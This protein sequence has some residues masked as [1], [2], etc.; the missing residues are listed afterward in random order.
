MM[1]PYRARRI[2]VT[3]LSFSFSAAT[4]VSG[5]PAA[6][7]SS[8]RPV[9]GVYF[10]E[11]FKLVEPF[12]RDFRRSCSCVENAFALIPRIVDP[13]FDT[14]KTDSLR[15][16]GEVLRALRETILVGLREDWVFS[17][18][19][20]PR[21][22]ITVSGI[23]ELE[24]QTAVA[25]AARGYLE[26]AEQGDSSAQAELG[27]LFAV[28]LGVAQDDR[29]AAYWYQQAAL[30]NIPD[31]SK[32]MAAMYALGRGV[33]R[34]DQAAFYWLL[35]ARNLQ[36]LAD[37]YACGLGVEQD[38]EHAR[39]LYE[40]EADRG[41]RDTQYQL[42]TMYL[43]GC[44]V[45]LNDELAHKWF[46]KSANNGHPEAQIA[47]SEMNN[48]G[49]DGVPDPKMSLVWAEFALKRLAHEDPSRVRALAAR[50]HADSLLSADDRAHAQWLVRT[51][52]EAEAEGRTQLL[53]G[54]LSELR[55]AASR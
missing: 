1:T 22:L 14:S 21:L 37:A 49:W 43:S 12:D 36:L 19:L 55:E 13:P 53:K 40:I 47:M 52:L 54:F 51:A 17:G 3:L 45:P 46:E 28:G 39:Q 27:Y 34:D 18:T 5:Q 38:F 42:G 30:Q 11:P 16:E 10:D 26:L 4:A 2:I 7:V 48:R 32:A 20:S 44:G 41:N 33:P 9:V 50:S 15:L 6:R 8:N 23:P 31:A 35:H 29:A 25:L 24:P